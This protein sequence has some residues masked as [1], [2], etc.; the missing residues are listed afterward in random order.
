[1]LITAES[2]DLPE[3]LI[4]FCLY[5]WQLFVRNPKIIVINKYD[6]EQKL[7]NYLV[8]GDVCSNVG[9]HFRNYIFDT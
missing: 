2:V 7:L 9:A 4:I 1:M 6:L 5:I 3:L 8:F